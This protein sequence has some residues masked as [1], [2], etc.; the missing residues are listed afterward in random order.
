MYYLIE[1]STGDAKVAGKAIYTYTNENDVIA[2][3]HSKLGVAMKS[4][5]YNTE[6]LM[7]I[8]DN[9]KVLEQRR[10]I[11]FDLRYDNVNLADFVTADA[12]S[13]RS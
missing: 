1:I 11:K 4:E 8:D 9:G 13:E 12:T 2:N 7:A 3:F 10:Y 5:L 6:L